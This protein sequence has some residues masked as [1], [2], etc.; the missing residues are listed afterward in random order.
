MTYSGPTMARRSLLHDYRFDLDYLNAHAISLNY[1][2]KLNAL[3][4][5]VLRSRSMTPQK[6]PIVFQAPGTFYTRIRS[7]VML[8]VECKIASTCD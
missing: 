2:N 8:Q 5:C 3:M 1:V 4:N 7:T 6:P